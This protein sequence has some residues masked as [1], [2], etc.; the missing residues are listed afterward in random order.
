MFSS[1]MRGSFVH[2]LSV[3]KKQVCDWTVGI[4]WRP[5]LVSLAASDPKADPWRSF[6]ELTHQEDARDVARKVPWKDADLPPGTART[7]LEGSGR[8]SSCLG[9]TSRGIYW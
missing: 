3:Q 7:L 1:R 4:C 5:G 2:E 8:F 9:K 6:G